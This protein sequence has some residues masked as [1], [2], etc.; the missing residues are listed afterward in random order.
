MTFADLIFFR[1]KAENYFESTSVE[2]NEANCLKPS[3]IRNWELFYIC[4]YPNAPPRSKYDTRSIFKRFTTGS[5]L[6]FSFS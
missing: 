2:N 3:N 4:I 1:L 6:E 5:N